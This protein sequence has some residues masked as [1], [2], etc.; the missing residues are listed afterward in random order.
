MRKLTFTDLEELREQVRVEL[1]LH[2]IP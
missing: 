2:S 1:A